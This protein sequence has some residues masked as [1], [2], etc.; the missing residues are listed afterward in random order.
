VTGGPAGPR[1]DEALRARAHDR[2]AALERRAISLAGRRPAAVAVVLLPDG[3]GRAAFLLTRRAPGLRA[4][5]GQWALP[6]GRLDPGESAPGAALRELAEEVGLELAA[7]AVLGTLDD[8]A[9]RSGFVVTPVVVWAGPVPDLRVNPAEVSAA[10]RVPLAD[11]NAPGVPRLVP[12]P[13]RAHPMIQLPLLD[14]LIHAPTA[15]ILYQLREVVLHG[16]PTRVAWLEEPPWADT[17]GPGA[18]PP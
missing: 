2:L 12:L 3:D 7:S 11:L 9:T 13:D 18:T 14:T 15:A 1:H 5:R 4:H 17:A 10:Y 8:Y 16:R 6:G